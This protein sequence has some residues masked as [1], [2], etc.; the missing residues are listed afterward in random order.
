MYISIRRSVELLSPE[1]SNMCCPVGE[2]DVTVKEVGMN[3]F[4]GISVVND[5]AIMIILSVRVR[6]ESLCKLVRYMANMHNI[7]F[8]G[9]LVWPPLSGL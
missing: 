6:R 2:F 4:D 3:Y 5:H 8:C 9:D 7:T 1:I